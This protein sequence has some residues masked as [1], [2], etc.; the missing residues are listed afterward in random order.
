MRIYN[1]R[2]VPVY[3]LVHGTCIRRDMVNVCVLQMCTVYKYIDLKCVQ[4][5][6]LAHRRQR[7]RK[8]NFLSTCLTTHTHTLTQYERM[9]DIQSSVKLLV[10]LSPLSVSSIEFFF[11]RVQF[12]LCFIRF[13]HTYKRFGIDC[14]RSERSLGRMNSVCV[15]VWQQQST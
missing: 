8:C 15:C 7:Q 14:M 10:V 1:T 2:R 13:V 9:E 5:P 4:C 6:V 11:R 12:H 3:T